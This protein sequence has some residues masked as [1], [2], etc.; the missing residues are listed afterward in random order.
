MKKPEVQQPFQ[1]SG[2]FLSLFG[3]STVMFLFGLL[4]D[5]TLRAFGIGISS[6]FDSLWESFLGT[7]FGSFIAPIFWR[8]GL[9]TFPQYLLGAFALVVP[10]TILSVLFLSQFR[11]VGISVPGIDSELHPNQHFAT[12]AYIRLFR[13][14]LFVPVYLAFFYWMF[15]VSLGM[16]PRR[17][18]V[19]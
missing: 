14:M 7:F 15:H 8:I 6:W 4:M 9:I 11:D 17:P 10:I 12:T 13:A 16:K 5:N 19:E 2:F 1:W 18:D 3:A